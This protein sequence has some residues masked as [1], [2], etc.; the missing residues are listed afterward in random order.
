MPLVRFKHFCLRTSVFFPGAAVSHIAWVLNQHPVSQFKVSYS[1]LTLLIL[2]CM[3][4][5]FPSTH[6]IHHTKFFDSSWHSKQCGEK[7]EEQREHMHS[8]RQKSSL[9]HEAWCRLP[10][11]SPVHPHPVNAYISMCTSRSVTAQMYNR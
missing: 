2:L 10:M 6:S 5:S 4:F 9:D 7:A 11:C 3:A 1:F 8:G